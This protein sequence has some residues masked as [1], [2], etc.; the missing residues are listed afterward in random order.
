M[1][2]FL[3]LLPEE[4]FQWHGNVLS[5]DLNPECEESAVLPRLLGRRT[6]PYTENVVVSSGT[7][8]RRSLCNVDL[9]RCTERRPEIILSLQLLPY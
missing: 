3:L 7:W 9:V 4:V 6:H 2:V 5:H 8:H 1:V